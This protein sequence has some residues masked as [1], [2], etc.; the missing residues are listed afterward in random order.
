MWF[1]VALGFL[2]SF[3]V[4]LLI[5]AM[6]LVVGVAAGERNVFEGRSASGKRYRDALVR[7]GVDLAADQMSAVL[8][9]ETIGFVEPGPKQ[10]EN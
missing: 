9:G 1:A 3:A 2:T 10:Y 5:G 7:H 8:S 6:A 4:C